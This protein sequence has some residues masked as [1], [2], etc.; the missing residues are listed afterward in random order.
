MHEKNV[1]FHIH[2]VNGIKVTEFLG[3][4]SYAEKNTGQTVLFPSG[5][6]FLVCKVEEK[7]D[8]ASKKRSTHIYLR[9]VE[10]GLGQQTTVMWTD[11]QLVSSYSYAPFKNLWAYK[12]QRSKNYY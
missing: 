1:I 12:T 9:N 2:S 8:E 5:A 7:I 4:Q 6:E 11:D 3:Y 10:L